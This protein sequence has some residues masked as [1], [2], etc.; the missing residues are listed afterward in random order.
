MSSIISRQRGG[1]VRALALDSD[2]ASWH[3]DMCIGMPA[4]IVPVGRHDGLKL[5]PAQGFECHQ[6]DFKNPATLCKIGC[7][8]S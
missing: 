2:V 8:L 1:R 7:T 3:R 4:A 6:T 5:I